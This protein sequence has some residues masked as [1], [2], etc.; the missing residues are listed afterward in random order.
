MM[1]ELWSLPSRSSQSN[2]GRA[3]WKVTVNITSQG[4]QQGYMQRATLQNSWAEPGASVFQFTIA[5]RP[6]PNTQHYN[7]ESKSQRW[8]LRTPGYNPRQFTSEFYSHNFYYSHY[9]N[10]IHIYSGF[11]ISTLFSTSITQGNLHNT[12]AI[13]CN[14]VYAVQNA[15][16]HRKSWT[17]HWCCYILSNF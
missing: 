5:P 7:T 9:S 3:L 2:E 4:N 16:I 6:P 8:G 11:I 14:T 17:C 10:F 13:Y 15:A 12:D 1:N